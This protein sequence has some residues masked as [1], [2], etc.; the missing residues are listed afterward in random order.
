VPK[1][2][3]KIAGKPS[4]GWKEIALQLKRTEMDCVGKYNSMKPFTGIFTQEEDNLVCEFM[5]EH[6]Y[7]GGY[8]TDIPWAE[9]A[10]VLNMCRDDLK[11]RFEIMEIEKHAIVCFREGDGVTRFVNESLY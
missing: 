8:F 10:G 5:G 4:I 7:K 6:T 11:T 2:A 9:C 3:K 1:N